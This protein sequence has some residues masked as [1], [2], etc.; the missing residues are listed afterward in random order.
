MESVESTRD[1]RARS[2]AKGLFEAA[3]SWIATHTSLAELK[4]CNGMMLSMGG[5][6]VLEV[7]SLFPCLK[8]PG[9]SLFAGDSTSAAVIAPMQRNDR[10]NGMC[11]L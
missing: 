2:M 4:I 11:N 6:Q 8:S 10:R 3:S 1:S 5:V 7:S 9:K